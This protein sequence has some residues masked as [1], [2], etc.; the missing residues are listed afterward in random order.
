M[1]KSAAPPAVTRRN[2]LAA[3]VPL[4][5]AA[6]AGLPSRAR[7]AAGPARPADPL[8]AGENAIDLHTDGGY[9]TV[10]LRKEAISIAVVQ[11]RVRHVDAGNPKPGLKANL[12]HMIELIDEAQHGGLFPKHDLLFFHEFALTGYSDRWD[13]KDVLKLAIEL[14]GEETEA[15][16]A[17]ARE[18]DCYIVFGSYARDRDWPGHVLS[19]AT[20]LAPSGQIINKSWKARD[21]RGVWAGGTFEVFTSTIFDNLSRFVEMYGWDAVVPVVRTD[22]GNFTTTSTQGDPELPRAAAMKGCEIF[23]RTATGGFTPVDAQAD[24]YYNGIYSCVANNAISPDNPGF[25]PS[26]GGFGISQGYGGSVAYGPRGELLSRAS[27]DN[28]EQEIVVPIPI[29]A[30]RRFHRQP[31]AYMDLYRPVFD[32]YVGAYPPDILAKTL[33]PDGEAMAR[34]V[35]GKWRWAR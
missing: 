13:R 11:M 9:S 12:A 33:P 29:G 3:A 34:Y 17:K 25:F 23:L 27:A 31:M 8:P 22:I 26:G 6:A 4:G 32:R 24:A 15:L 5:M 35:A 1:K 28:Q 7:A 30:F 21:L 2:V 18:H 20:T 14:P 10:P 16:A 19:I